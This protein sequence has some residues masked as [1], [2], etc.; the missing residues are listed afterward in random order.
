MKHGEPHESDSVKVE[1]HLKNLHYLWKQA[2]RSFTI[3]HVVQ[4][5]RQFQRID[6][7]LDDDVEQIH[8]ISAK[9]E[10]RV[11]WMKDK[12]QQKMYIQ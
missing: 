10:A 8:Q 1:Q 4:Q 2:Q 7:T 11:S 3:S 6:H 12:G 9:I 5:I